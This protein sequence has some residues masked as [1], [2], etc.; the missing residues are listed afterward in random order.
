MHICSFYYYYFLIIWHRRYSQR[1]QRVQCVEGSRAHGG[2][3]VVVEWQETHGAQAHEAA[4]AHTADVVT[5][6]H[7]AHQD[8]GTVIFNINVIITLR[9][10][11]GA[12]V[13]VCMCVCTHSVR[14]P[15]SPFSM[16]WCTFSSLLEVKINSLTPEAPSNVPSSMS[17]MR[18]LLRLLQRKRQEEMHY[19][20]F[21]Q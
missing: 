6:Q 16:P 9:F 19:G 8:N 13:C 15:L 11:S 4:V 2:D 14:R 5:P 21:T 18:L 7:A 1:G 12:R 17:V 3:L 10:S 20:Q